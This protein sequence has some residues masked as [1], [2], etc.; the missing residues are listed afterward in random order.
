MNRRVAPRTRR[1][2]PA[3]GRRPG[4][5]PRRLG[6]EAPAPQ[7]AE[8]RPGH[9]H[10]VAHLGYHPRRALPPLAADA[11][12][13]ASQHPD[14][15]AVMA[16]TQ[17]REKEQKIARR[18]RLGRSPRPADGQPGHL[19]QR[20]RHWLHRP[21][22]RRPEG[23]ADQAG[24]WT[25]GPTPPACGTRS[26]TASPPSTRPPPPLH[27]QGL[28]ARGGARPERPP[29]LGG[30]AAGQ[31]P[32][33]PAPGRA[34]RA[35]RL[36]ARRRHLRVAH[37]R[38]QRPL[39]SADGKKAAFGGT[40]GQQT[41]EYLTDFVWTV[42]GGPARLAAGGGGGA[43]PQGT[44]KAGFNVDGPFQYPD[45]GGGPHSSSASP[46][47]PAPRGAS[48]PIN[49]SST[50]STPPPPPPA[51]ATPPGPSP[52]G[53][54]RRGAPLVHARPEAPRGDQEV[55]RRPRATPGSTPTGR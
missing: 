4:R 5:P 11:H 13:A 9:G 2:V 25:R 31:P 14:R 44:S 12:R 8:Q 32:G 37:L 22:G 51:G 33:H 53:R 18:H 38:P 27:Q 43:F 45:P 6:E 41:I 23:G 26:S 1:T 21:P 24:E 16:V 55:Q 34:V 20:R 52:V 15:P 10:H 19:R 46:P 28:P 17:D 30:A 48:W 54:P 3:R 35:H 36:A 47:S 39:F 50:G 40:E 7:R 42:Y 49:C 29:D